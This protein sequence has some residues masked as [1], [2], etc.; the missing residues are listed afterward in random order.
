LFGWF[1]PVLGLW[2]GTILQWLVP[3]LLAAYFFTQRQTTAFA[4]C[5]FFFF[6]N[7]LYTA[8]YMADARA[9]ALPLVT[10]GNSDYVEHDWNTIFSGL[11]V[12]QYDTRIAALVRGLGWC[13][14]LGT[15]AW[16]VAL[17]WNRETMENPSPVP[18]EQ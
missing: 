7:W 15:V 6:E 10:A 2:G 14:M 8:S 4:F 3:L 1:G 12:L 18:K 16:L 11:G 13:G 5:L 9:M 17:S